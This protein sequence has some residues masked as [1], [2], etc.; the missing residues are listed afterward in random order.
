[1]FWTKF[2]Q[3]FSFFATY[4]I[5]HDSELTVI[6]Y[7]N[8]SHFHTSV[9]FPSRL[10]LAQPYDFRSADGLQYKCGRW[11]PS[12][13][14]SCVSGFSFQLCFVWIKEVVC[15]LALMAPC[16]VGLVTFLS[17]WMFWPVL[18][19]SLFSCFCFR[20]WEGRLLFF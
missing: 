11:V 20:A 7:I 18:H 12:C 8:N 9:S 17:F 13:C 2:G 19:V 4:S 3:L 15:W 10:C 5:S 1:M 16:R 6:Y 14:L